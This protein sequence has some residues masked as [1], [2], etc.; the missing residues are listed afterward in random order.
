M[1]RL[2]R[3]C[4]VPI[5]VDCVGERCRVIRAYCLLR[6]PVR[7]VHPGRPRPASALSR[8]LVAFA[9]VR[10]ADAG[11]VTPSVAMHRHPVMP[12]SACTQIQ[13]RDELLKN[14]ILALAISL[15]VA[16]CTTFSDDGGFRA[17][18][19]TAK[20]R[21]DKDVKWIRTE[22][23]ADSLKG[24]LTKLLAAPLSVDDAVQIALLNNRGLQAIYAE[25][26]IAEADLVQAGRIRNP[27]TV[28]PG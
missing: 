13:A 8:S 23:D 3:G 15:V 10:V 26:A 20:D 6:S 16:G 7:R 21:L 19:V 17:V 27:I 9:L 24:T 14:T 12:V 11:G 28:S 18:E 25:L 22:G 2:L 1:R 5:G 4:V